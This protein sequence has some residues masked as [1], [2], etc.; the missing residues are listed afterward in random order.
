MPQ[1]ITLHNHHFENLKSYSY[2]ANKDAEKLTTLEFV[3]LNEDKV[4]SELKNY[5]TRGMDISPTH[6]K[7]WNK[8][9]VISLLMTKAKPASKTLL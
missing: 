4:I 8:T 1:D 3:C 6:S 2:I 9:A 7:S 5:T